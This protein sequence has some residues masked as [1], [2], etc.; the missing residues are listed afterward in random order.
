MTLSN[1]APKGHVM[2]MELSEALSLRAAAQ[3]LSVSPRTIYRLI[4]EQ[5]LPTV[6]LGRRHVVRRDAL[7]A[8]LIAR[9]T[10]S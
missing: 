5:G 1:E 4:A 2:Q 9:E 10:V 6:R 8:W 7:R 3:A